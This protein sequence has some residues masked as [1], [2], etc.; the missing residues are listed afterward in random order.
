M[1]KVL[2]F[3]LCIACMCGVLAACG[4][5]AAKEYTKEVIKLNEQVAAT[6]NVLAD[7]CALL[8]DV[9]EIQ[10]LAMEFEDIARQHES[11]IEALGMKYEGKLNADDGVATV[12]FLT[13]I[14]ELQDAANAVTAALQAA[15][16]RLQLGQ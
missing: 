10:E 4:N 15:A 3:V 1:K 2:A 9:A 5:N 8:E 6:Y 14:Q 16:L 11:N 12:E 7:R 13:S